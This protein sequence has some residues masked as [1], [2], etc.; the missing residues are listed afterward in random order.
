M[1]RHLLE[2]QQL[3]CDHLTLSQAAA[4][5]LCTVLRVQLGATIEAFDGQGG[6]RVMRVVSVR[7]HEIE[8]CAVGELR[9][10]APPALKI[11]LFAAMIK[12]ERMDWMVEKAV[13]IGMTRLV[14]VITARTIAHS[15]SI[16][17]WQRV[18]AAAVRQCGTYWLPE[19]QEP[20]RFEQ[21]MEF[22]AQLRPTFVGSLQP[23]TQVL[24]DV[25]AGFEV[26]PRAVGWF[27]GPE[28]DFTADELAQLQAAQCYPVSL[29]TRVLRAET[30]CVYGLSVLS[31]VWGTLK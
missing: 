6:A 22:C 31:A 19:I 24:H 13:E 8:L 12:G 30:A 7:R 11:T 16:A 29:G 1:H 2:K 21:A 15:K 26:R 25:L 4:R 17:R 3:E 10:Y 23:G 28:G 9:Q 20:V 14:P 27:V 18:A 5:H